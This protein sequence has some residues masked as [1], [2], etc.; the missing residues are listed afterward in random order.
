MN[1]RMGFEPE[2]PERTETSER[3]FEMAIGDT[4]IS[5]YPAERGF[6][7]HPYQ[8]PYVT[9]ENLPGLKARSETVANLGPV[10]H[11]VG[12]GRPE[13]IMAQASILKPKAITLIDLDG[14]NI[15][16]A[17]SI[18]NALKHD[19]SI[20]E[21]FQA[22]SEE[23]ERFID[24]LHAMF[25]GSNEMDR[26]QSNEGLNFILNK[27]GLKLEDAATAAK[28]TAKINLVRGNVKD[29]TILKQALSAVAVEGKTVCDFFQYTI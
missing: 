4:N 22:H 11:L 27:I 17:I 8:Y 6:K 20:E 19:I 1:E 2:M 28:N 16:D 5:V 9:N 21:A 25:V 26:W 10:G 29:P 18:F 24:Q 23:I 12:V 3:L 13:K 7:R 15:I 14:Q